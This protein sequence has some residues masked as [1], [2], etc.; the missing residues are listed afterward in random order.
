MDVR[1]DETGGAVRQQA[2]S[3]RAGL[4]R[5]TV[6]TAVLGVVC[7]LMLSACEPVF[8][9]AGGELSGTDE[10][11]P[12]SWDFAAEVDTVQIETRPADPYSVNVWGVGVGADFYVAASDGPE[13][14]WAHAIE[15]DGNVRLKVAGR[16]FPLAAERVEGAEEL[17]RVV[18]AYAAKYDVDRDESFVDAAWVY[19]LDPR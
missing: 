1:R 3:A 11:H 10:A 18:D 7:A 4:R 12:E 6:G 14:R 9:F 16:V 17:A 5:R 2:P 13:A 15:A 19:R 8:I